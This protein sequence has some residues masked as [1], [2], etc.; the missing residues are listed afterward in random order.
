M[1][2][3]DSRCTVCGEEYKDT[4]GTGPPVPSTPDTPDDG[5]GNWFTKLLKKIGDFFGTTIGGLLDLIGAALGKIL[6]SLI[7][8]VENTIGKLKELV[9]LFGS[10]GEALGVLWTWL[11]PE[12]MTVLV[13][14]VTV[15]IFVALLKLF[16][17]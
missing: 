6:D 10:F 3:R 13:A 5:E 14:G 7:T 11:P 9:N 1:C 15:F 8:L 2:I 12:I 4:D 17:K 16:L